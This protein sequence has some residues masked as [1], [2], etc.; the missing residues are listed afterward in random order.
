[1]NVRHAMGALYSFSIENIFYDEID[2]HFHVTTNLN[3]SI[4]KIQNASTR[5]ITQP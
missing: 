1:M 2:F 3:P 4:K 5:N